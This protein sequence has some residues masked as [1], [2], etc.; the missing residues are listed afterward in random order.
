M[1]EF[2]SHISLSIEGKTGKLGLIETITDYINTLLACFGWYT[3]NHI[4]ENIYSQVYVYI[5]SDRGINHINLTA[6]TRPKP[7]TDCIN[8]NL[9]IQGIWE[10]KTFFKTNRMRSQVIYTILLSAL[11]SE[12]PRALVESSCWCRL[13]ESLWWSD[14]DFVIIPHP[15]HLNCSIII[16]IVKIH[17]LKGYCKNYCKNKAFNKYFFLLIELEGIGSACPIIPLLHLTLEDDIFEDVYTASGK[18]T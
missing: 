14:H 12:R 18:S 10:T 9:I 11:S 7:A 13:N 16:V 8:V 15:R 5:A 17:L 6:K 2:D 3:L 1:T 4:E